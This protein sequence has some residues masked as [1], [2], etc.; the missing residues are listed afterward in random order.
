M[1][2]LDEA[3]MQNI[4]ELYKERNLWNTDDEVNENLIYTIF[5]TFGFSIW[6][7]YKMSPEEVAKYVHDKEYVSLYKK[8]FAPD[9]KP[10]IFTVHR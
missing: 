9:I 3:T 5:D 4:R 10:V 2:N 1:S 7:F 8:L 6:R